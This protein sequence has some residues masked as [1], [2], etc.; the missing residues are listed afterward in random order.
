MAAT[1]S[2]PQGVDKE[3]RNARRERYRET[4]VNSISKESSH[5]DLAKAHVY[6]KQAHELRT[7]LSDSFS[8]RGI[9]IAV[10]KL[11]MLKK[12]FTFTYFDELLKKPTEV[13]YTGFPQRFETLSRILTELKTDN[14][15]TGEEAAVASLPF[16][17]ME[18]TLSPQQQAG[19]LV[20][21]G[22]RTADWRHKTYNCRV[23]VN[24]T[25]FRRAN[26]IT[27]HWGRIAGNRNA[28]LGIQVFDPDPKKLVEVAKAMAKRR[29]NDP[30]PILD[31]YGNVFFP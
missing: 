4:I 13:T 26:R 12:Q 6:E 18:E 24:P 22:E 14:M 23:F 16:A 27:P 5:F 7:H 19:K 15:L 25:Y 8:Q 1:G 11:K 2:L 9:G 20:G 3:M 21:Y 10:Q 29:P 28:I 30:I 17:T 31:L